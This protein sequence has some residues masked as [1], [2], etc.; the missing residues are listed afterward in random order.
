MARL[1]YYIVETNR[2]IVKAEVKTLYLEQDKF[3]YFEK[4]M[5]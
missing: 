2:G 5:A 3:I 1:Y 4:I